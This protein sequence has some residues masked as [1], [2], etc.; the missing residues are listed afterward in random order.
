MTFWCLSSR[1]GCK[2]PCNALYGVLEAGKGVYITPTENEAGKSHKSRL[3]YPLNVHS[4]A[5]PYSE[6]L[7]IEKLQKIFAMHLANVVNIE[8]NNSAS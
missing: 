1:K 6:L 7:F 5:L 8:Y 3:F 2:S 4:A